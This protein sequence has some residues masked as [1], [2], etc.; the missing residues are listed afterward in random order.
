MICISPNIIS[1]GLLQYFTNFWQVLK[2]VCETRKGSS[3]FLTT[4]R[5]ALKKSFGDDTVCKYSFFKKNLK[6]CFRPNLPFPGDFACTYAI[7]TFII[8]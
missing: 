4:I 1:V 7:P 5:E 8:K 3:D 6:I 2:I